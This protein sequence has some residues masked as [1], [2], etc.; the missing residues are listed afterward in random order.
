MANIYITARFDEAALVGLRERHAVTYESWRDTGI[1]PT[2]QQLVER[3]NEES[4]E[5]YVNEGDKVPADVVAQLRTTRLICVARATPDNV[6]I[7]AATRA[8]ILVTRC[9]GRNAVAVA[10]Y[11]IGVALCLARRIVQGNRMVLEGTWAFDRYDELEGFELCGRTFGIVGV[12]HVGRAVAQR[13]RAFKMSV[14]GFDPYVDP[15]LARSAGVEL[16]SLD[17]LLRTAD[18]VSIHAAV[19][20]ETTGLIGAREIA[21]MKPS[22][23]L[24]NTARAYIVDEGALYRALRRRR[25][26]GAAL[27]VFANEPVTRQDPLATLANV[28][29]TPHMGGAA[30]DVVSNHSHMIVRAIEDYVRGDVPLHAVNPEARTR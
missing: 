3:L 14:L 20:P 26:A 21:L 1:F 9:P 8:G 19:T 12:G 27:D 29:T 17:E 28:L 13:L 6:D 10:E 25:I 23:Y 5:I 22:A 15:T 7:S 11:T 16:V 2:G 30:R 4:F 18:F 24:I